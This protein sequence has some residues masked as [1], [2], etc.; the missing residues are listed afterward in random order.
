LIFRYGSSEWEM[1]D[2]H[3]NPLPH[4]FQFGNDDY[5]WNRL[6]YKAL[7]ILPAGHLSARPP[8]DFLLL[9][10]PFDLQIKVFVEKM[11][12]HEREGI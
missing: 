7:E 4:P 10:C 5:G 12:T 11:E 1:E 9:V 2:G 8:H 3:G 6:L